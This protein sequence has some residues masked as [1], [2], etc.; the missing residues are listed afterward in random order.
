MPEGVL[1]DL[2]SVEQWNWFARKIGCACKVIVDWLESVI[3]SVDQD[4]IDPPLL[5]FASEEAYAK[6][7][8]LDE[9]GRQRFSA[10]TGNPR[11]E[12]RRR[13]PAVRRP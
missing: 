4:L 12:I 3:V 1:R 10:S 6:V 7:L 2:F 5:G 13:I 9:V 11:H 8:S